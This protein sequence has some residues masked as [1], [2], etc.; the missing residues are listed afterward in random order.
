VSFVGI[1][2]VK[3]MIYFRPLKEKFPVFY[4]LVRF[5][6]K[7]HTGDMHKILLYNF[8]SRQNRCIECH[9]L[10]RGVNEF[11]TENSLTECNSGTNKK[12]DIWR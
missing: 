10:L 12:L 7:F 6:Q 1:G 8:E 4:T 2:A 3:A 5:G 11:L 9:T